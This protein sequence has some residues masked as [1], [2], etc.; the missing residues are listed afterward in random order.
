M[1]NS[2]I[3]LMF[4]GVSLKLSAQDVLFS[5]PEYSQLSINPGLAANNQDVQVNLAYRNQWMRL[6][7][8][9]N[10]IMAS[11]DV[12]LNA[13]KEPGESYFGLG[14]DVFND[15]AG[16]SKV[17]TTTLKVSCSYHLSLNRQNRLSLGVY[18]GYFGLSNNLSNSTWGSQYDGYQYNSGIVSGEV[19]NG[20]HKNQLDLGVGLV[21]TNKDLKSRKNPVFQTG[22][23]LYHINQPNISVLN[24]ISRLP[25]R[26]ASFFK[27]GLPLNRKQEL[28]PACYL[29][30]QGKFM[31]YLAGFDWQFKLQ[32]GAK[33]TSSATQ[34]EVLAVTCG[35]F[36]RSTG[37]VVAKVAFQKS[38]WSCGL[39]YDF[40]AAFSRSV[41]TTKG[42]TEI[43]LR[44]ILKSTKPYLN[45]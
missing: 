38:Y 21:Y 41:L 33:F 31:N 10:T 18:S 32:E 9:Y 23:S 24:N 26:Y 43:Y 14:L 6:G 4:I 35:L 28:Q 17:N 19:T 5:S 3:V 20:Q 7:S 16:D 27:M 8:P 30:M 45:Y 13:N 40:N 25:I 37:A 36:Y 12:A 11:G 42:A 29:N 15:A 34:M 1:K 2:F 44:F 39:A 22:L